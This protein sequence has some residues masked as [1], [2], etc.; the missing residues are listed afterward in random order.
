VQHH[1]GE[2][3]ILNALSLESSPPLSVAG[4]VAS[5]R[6][7]RRQ[8]GRGRGPPVDPLA[9]ECDKIDAVR[10]PQDPPFNPYDAR[11][12]SPLTAEELS[13]WLDILGNFTEEATMGRPRP[14]PQLPEVT[15]RDSRGCPGGRASEMCGHA[16]CGVAVLLCALPSSGQTSA[17]LAFVLP[18]KGGPVGIRQWIETGR[19][20]HA[21]VYL[22]HILQKLEPWSNRGG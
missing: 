10:S 8:S 3:Y 20:R 22:A 2:S 17:D 16:D 21:D 18:P 7:L 11:V 1:D 4:Y 9:K 19:C 6:V 14:G 13:F 12:P 5:L 15:V